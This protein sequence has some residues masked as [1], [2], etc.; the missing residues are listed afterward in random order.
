MPGKSTILA[1]TVLFSGFVISAQ[2]KEASRPPTTVQWSLS[3]DFTE[4][5]NIPLD[6]LFPLFHRYRI[7]DKYS[8]F[9]AWMGNYGQPLYQINFF[10]RI[11]NPDMFLYRY[12]YPFMYLPSNPV[13]MNT[14][15]PFTEM[16]F[17]YAGPREMA[18]QT[19][20]IR[21]SQNV[22]R[23]L[24]FGLIYD[25]IYSLGQYSYQRTDDKSFTFFSSYTGQKYKLY[26]SSGINS[27]TTFENGGITDEEQL[28]TFKT[29]D[30]EV[31]LGAL[32]KARNV[33]KNSNILLVQRLS[34][35]GKP[36]KRDSISTPREGIRGLNGTIS[37][38]FIWER[39]RRSY[40]DS[41]PLSGFYDTSH[42]YIS[43][44]VTFDSLSER[45]IKN[46]LR[47]DFSTDPERKFR[48][49]GGVG[50]S[51]ELFRYSQI[52]PS[53]ENPPSDTVH[54]THHNNLLKGSLFN[55]IGEK[56]K[57]R[58]TGELYL[59]GYRA[60]DFIADGYIYKVFGQKEKGISLKITGGFSSVKPS[61][62]VFRWGSNHF[63]WDNNFL[64]EFRVNAGAEVS[65]PYRRL[66]TRFNYTVIDNF[67][68]FGPDSMP[69]QHRGGLSVAALYG[70]KELSLWKFH[71]SNQILIQKSSNRDILDLPLITL[72]TAGFF[73]HNFYFKLTGGNLNTQ[74]GVE[75]FY[76][77]KYYG[78]GYVPAT[79]SYFRQNKTLIGN[80]PYIN[81]FL[82]VK[83]KRTRVFLVLDHINSGFTGYN[84]FMVPG[85]PMNVRAFRYGLAWTFYD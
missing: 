75:L 41:Y 4:E 68:D 35:T 26:F 8:P 48:L 61:V 21:H 11:T 19:F 60:G 85:Y 73:E 42:I 62:W 17:T 39:T 69:A 14:R 55:D 45:S 80:Y 53:A 50:I 59:T 70:E 37:H 76:N 52:I 15:V 65:Y 77:T 12:Y 49:G 51:N 78:Y 63:V 43:R 47:F 24:N 13:F 5:I 27:L 79:G 28:K 82:N 2:E 81:A 33:L 7:A 16:V 83:I 9:N 57:W 30:V 6:T 56:F 38:I 20:R 58:A 10:D 74:I 66:N 54:W 1:L 36:Q 23:Y 64:K 3:K 84:Y 34:L 18:D 46:T 22:N 31:R 32:N 25:I 29:R 71:L 72:R 67:T 44:T 40:S